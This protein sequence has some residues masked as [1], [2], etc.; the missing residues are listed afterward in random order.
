MRDTISRKE[1]IDILKRYK[2]I[3][4]IKDKDE[5]VKAMFD[6]AKKNFELENIK[7]LELIYKKDSDKYM[8]DGALGTVSASASVSVK[9]TNQKK[10]IC[11]VIHHELRHIKQKYYALNYDTERFIN[12]INSKQTGPLGKY[13]ASK[14]DLEVIWGIKIDKKNVPEKY[15]EFAKKVL[16]N[17]EHYITPSVD[18]NAYRNQFVEEDAYN[19]GNKI[20][21]I[22]KSLKNKL[23]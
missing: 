12:I 15:Q 4:K 2:E 8:T 9:T 17:Q 16:D 1:T 13:K 14:E 5:Y 6:E 22:I 18:K 19:C 21:S 3:E 7:E 20:E 10:D 23:I 11:N